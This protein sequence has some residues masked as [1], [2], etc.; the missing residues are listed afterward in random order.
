MNNFY[1]PIL[2]KLIKALSSLPGIGEKSANRLALFLISKVSLCELLGDLLKELPYKVKLCQI[3]RNFSEEHL[4]AICKDENRDPSKICIV[5][6]PWNLSQ[7]EGV[8]IYRGYYYVL[9]Y[10][11]APREGFGPQELGL[12]GLI[13]LIENR[14]IKE[15]VLALSP[16]L[17]GEA[18]SSYIAKVLENYPIKITKLACG[19]PMGMELQYADTLT[20]KRAFLGREVLKGTTR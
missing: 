17:A 18:T 16:T 10:L 9:H 19:V 2:Q 7:I 5:E 13:R 3:C 11:L 14:P 12:E 1:P 8:G 15:V 4:C 6:S 20:L